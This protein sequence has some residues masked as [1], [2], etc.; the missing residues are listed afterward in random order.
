MTDLMFDPL[1]RPI[2]IPL[3]AGFVCLLWPKRWE[4]MRAWLAIAASAAT[5][6]AVWPLFAQR[7]LLT[8]GEQASESG[9]LRVDPLSGFILLATAVFTLLIAV[10]SL[11]F[12]KGKRGQRLYYGCMMWSL[13]FACGVLLAGDLV[14]LV[15][16]WG[17]LAV[18]LYLM[19]GLA[20]P[21][22]SEA[23]RKTFMIIGGSD[24]LL[25]L[26]T[27]LLWAEH[28]STRMDA[29]AVTLVSATDYLALFCFGAAA[30]AKAGAIPLHSWLP[31]CGEK[32]HAPVT[33]FLPASLDK[34]LG[35]YLLARVV[36]DLFVMTDGMNNL[37]MMLGAFTIVSAVLMALVQHDLKRLLA[38]HAVSQVGYM[39]MGI[40]TGTALG[41]AAGLFHMLN[42][43]IYKSCLF[44]V[45]GVVEKRTGTVDLDRL[46]GLATRLPVTFAVCLI[47]SLS[48][49]GIPPLNGFASKWMVYQAVIDSGHDSG[50]MLWV[51]WLTAAVLGSALTL[52]SF[53]KVLHAVFLCKPSPHIRQTKIQKAA[54][55]MALPMMLLACLCVV[56]GVFAHAIPLRLLVEPAVGQPVT[57]SGTWWAGQASGLLLIAF[58]VGWI[59]YALT[60]RNGKLRKVPTYI[61]GERLDEARIPGVPKGP[62]RHV[63]VT[64]IDFYRTVEQLPVLNGFYQAAQTKIFDVYETVGR[65][66]AW[67]VNLLRVAHNG[68]LPMYLTWFV[69]GLLGVLYVIMEGTP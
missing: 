63:E 20:G 35:I 31:D 15:T 13:G 45:A 25:L 18:T 37:L 9:W 11:D 12:M 67:L 38:F 53:V 54:W 19:I 6:L 60:M 50:N 14:L 33:A 3:L 34:L 28:G 36:M 46:G 64:G 17:L 7:G 59:V 39:V 69:L 8:G 16:C 5:L 68:V 1:L 66:T 42:H 47:A 57:Y 48:I 65:S 41:L 30:F 55:P 44:L 51:V 61:G 49:S 29:G 43:A 26:G 4:P 27:A 22:A 21:D 56:F 58:G 10:Y 2:T 40:G 23:A 24:T 32:A 62:G 52:A